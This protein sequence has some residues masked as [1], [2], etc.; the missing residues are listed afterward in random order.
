MHHAP[1][2]YTPWRVA[3]M[4]KMLQWTLCFALL[5]QNLAYYTHLQARILL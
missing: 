5:S 2:I 1:E 3:Y 4:Q